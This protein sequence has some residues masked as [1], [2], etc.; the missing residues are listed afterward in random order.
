MAV[1]FFMPTFD[2]QTDESRSLLVLQNPARKVKRSPPE[3]DTV[4]Q[5]AKLRR[6]ENT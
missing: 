3:L 2:E 1:P 5:P 6:I 4:P